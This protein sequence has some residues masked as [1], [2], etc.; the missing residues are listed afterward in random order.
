MLGLDPNRFMHRGDKEQ[1]MERHYDLIIPVVVRGHSEEAVEEALSELVGEL[2]AQ[3]LEP[4]KHSGFDWGL[5]SS[6]RWIE[7]EQP[8]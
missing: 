5:V 1:E 3:A 8:R 4:P 7:P 2:T 6:V